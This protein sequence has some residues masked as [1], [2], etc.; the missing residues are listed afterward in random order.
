L[1]ARIVRRDVPSW[2]GP[3][4]EPESGA[5]TAPRPLLPLEVIHTGRLLRAAIAEPLRRWAIVLFLAGGPGRLRE[6]LRAV[7]QQVPWFRD[8]PRW[9]IAFAQLRRHGMT[10]LTTAEG[11]LARRLFR[12]ISPGGQQ[13]VSAR[14][15]NPE[16]RV[17][18]VP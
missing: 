10:V 15:F 3:L 11:A 18:L 8:F 6:D 12:D 5:S 13:R 1:S 17:R 7:C 4:P 14:L 2:S 16:G 9:G